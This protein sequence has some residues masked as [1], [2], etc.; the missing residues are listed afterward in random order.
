MALLVLAAAPDGRAFDRTVA[1]TF[2]AG[3][4]CVL[5]LDTY[6]GGIELKPVAEPEIRIEVSLAVLLDDGKVANQVLD[7]LQLDLHQNG[8]TVSV[9]ARNPSETRMRFVWEEKQRIRISYV[10]SVPPGCTVEIED[11]DGDIVIGDLTG[12]T[13]VHDHLGQISFRHVY[14]DIAATTDHGDII[15]SHCVGAA[16]LKSNGGMVRVGTIEGAA[17][18]HTTNG[19]IEVQHALGGITAFAE[20]G[21]ITSGFGKGFSRDAKFTTNGGAI[22]LYLDPAAH[23]TLAASS[24]WGHVS[25]ALPFAVQSGGSGR[26]TLNGQL[27]GGGPLL[28]VHADGGQVLISPPRI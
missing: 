21:D 8:P 18:F 12:R 20:A 4:G 27:N 5:H 13:S 14:G 1:R 28:T 16:T 3:P 15:G 25:T 10:V 23:C 6:R 11:N 17:D 22:T 24:V 19:D 26:K 7:R 9:V 2:P